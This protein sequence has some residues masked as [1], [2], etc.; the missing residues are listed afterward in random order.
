MSSAIEFYKRLTRM[1]DDKL[2]D[3]ELEVF[4]N[5]SDLTEE[6]S[7]HIKTGYFD[8]RLEGIYSDTHTNCFLDLLTIRSYAYER[9]LKVPEREISKY[10]LE[11]QDLRNKRGF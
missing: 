5:L 2:L 6:Y 7:E 8:G 1:S 4:T 11:I 3:Y 10:M 9:K